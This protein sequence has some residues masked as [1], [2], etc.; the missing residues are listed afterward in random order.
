MAS[1]RGPSAVAIVRTT[2]SDGQREVVAA[3]SCAATPPGARRGRAAPA[4]APTG[5][6]RGTRAACR[7]R[8]RRR[9]PTSG[10]SATGRSHMVTAPSPESRNRRRSR[11]TTTTTTS[12]DP[13]RTSRTV[14]T[15]V[16]AAGGRS[17]VGESGVLAGRPQPG[18]RPAG[19]VER[20]GFVAEPSARLRASRARS[21]SIS[22]EISAV[23]ARMETPA[24]GDREEAAVGRDDDVLAGV[25][26]DRHDAALGELAEQGRVTGQDTQLALGR[27][28][29]DHRGLAG[30]DLPLDGHQLD[31]QGRHD[32][33]RVSTR[34]GPAL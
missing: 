24:L 11:K 7:R 20:L 8:T 29:D 22:V 30:P 31:L 27:A 9:P 6:A 28:G 15:G 4:G 2:T 34:T 32:T 25:G 23:S 21:T 13:S 10:A 16:R 14:V 12:A 5:T 19:G 3:R 18:L 33:P 26:A 17:A 1:S